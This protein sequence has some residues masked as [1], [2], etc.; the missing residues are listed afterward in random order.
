M[1]T[2]TFTFLLISYGY[3]LY[4]KLVD[5]NGYNAFLK[6]HF[7][8]SFF[9]SN[10]KVL[11]ILLIIINTLTSLALIV[12][13]LNTLI[14]PNTP[15]LK[16]TLILTAINTLLLL[17]GQRIAKDFQGAANLGIYFILILFAWGML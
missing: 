8:M 2:L 16:G 15:L 6:Q 7:K 14:Q 9:S 12:S 10:S 4:E 1:L 3:S 11:L 13:T 5:F 17:I